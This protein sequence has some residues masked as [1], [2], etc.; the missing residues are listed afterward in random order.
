MVQ[1]LEDRQ[2]L[3][4]GLPGGRRAAEGTAGLAQAQERLG[5]VIAVAQPAVQGQG[6]LVAGE[7][8][9]VAAYAN[10]QQWIAQEMEQ[11]QSNASTIGIKLSLVPK[12]FSQVTAQP[13]GNCVVAKIPCG[14]DFGD[15]G[16]GWSFAPDYYPSGETLFTTG[17][18]ANSS[19][20]TDPRNDSMINQTLTNSSQQVLYN[21]QDYLA[22]QL[23]LEWQ[24]NAPYQLTEVSSNLRG[25]PV[26]RVDGERWV[27]REVLREVTRRGAH[28]PPHPTLAGRAEQSPGGR[29]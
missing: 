19:G 9:A 27:L 2:R 8:L 17:S 5:L 11:L 24:P 16:L 13:A 23:P 4:P 29:A 15:W 3:P 28:G 1:F 14:W 12:P 26:L 20:Y 21:W 6:P 10:G 25:V 18:V 22:K 7:R